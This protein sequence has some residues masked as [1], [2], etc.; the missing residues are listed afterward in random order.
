MLFI[1]GCSLS[2]VC[3]LSFAMC[4]LSVDVLFVDVC[5]LLLVGVFVVF[6]VLFIICLW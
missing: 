1:V 2:V 6:Y 5:S 3:Y 4:C